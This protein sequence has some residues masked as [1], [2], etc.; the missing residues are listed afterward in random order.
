MIIFKKMLPMSPRFLRVVGAC[1][2]CKTAKYNMQ[3]E[4]DDK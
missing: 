1:L 3:K 4:S 2:K